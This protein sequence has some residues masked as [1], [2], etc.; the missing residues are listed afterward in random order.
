MSDT[1]LIQHIH[2][3]KQAENTDGIFKKM[4]LKI[5]HAMWM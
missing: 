2:S 3:I 4:G 5:K 1:V